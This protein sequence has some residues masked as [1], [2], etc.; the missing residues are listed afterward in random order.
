MDEAGLAGVVAGGRHL[1]GEFGGFEVAGQARLDER[2]IP[3][4]V[5]VRLAG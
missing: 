2:A 4:A 5:K 3:C 1:D